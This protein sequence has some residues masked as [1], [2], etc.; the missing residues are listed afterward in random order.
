VHVEPVQS[1]TTG[2]AGGSKYTQ[3]VEN[4]VTCCATVPRRNAYRKRMK[5]LR[6]RGRCLL[7]EY[8]KMKDDET[9]FKARYDGF[10]TQLTTTPPPGG[11]VAR[12]TYAGQQ[13][14]PRV[15]RATK[16]IEFRKYDA[17]VWTISKWSGAGK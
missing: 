6:H 11:Y 7:D 9:S 10:Y 17:A 8:G 13:I 12:F 5:L 3:P 14:K 2:L 15:L 4:S 1:I 16:L